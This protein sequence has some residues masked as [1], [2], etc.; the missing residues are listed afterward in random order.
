MNIDFMRQSLQIYH[1]N[2]LAALDETKRLQGC[3][4]SALR[5]LHKISSH[6]DGYEPNAISAQQIAVDVLNSLKRQGA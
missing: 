6:I 3:L 5:G 2:I 1:D 4:D